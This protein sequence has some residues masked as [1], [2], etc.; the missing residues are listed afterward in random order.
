MVLD[1]PPS[2]E[3]AARTVTGLDP[4]LACQALD[5]QMVFDKALFP[6]LSRL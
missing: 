6:D 3:V 4:E 1:K 5:D 2:A